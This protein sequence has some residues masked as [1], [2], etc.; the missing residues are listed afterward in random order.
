[1]RLLITKMEV[2]TLPPHSTHV[3]TKKKASLLRIA[4]VSLS[5]SNTFNPL[6]YIID[7][8]FLWMKI[9]GERYFLAKLDTRAGKNSKQLNLV[10]DPLV[11]V[12][13][14]NISKFELQVL[15]EARCT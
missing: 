5:L 13:F 7:E 12:E 9:H 14:E 3:Y 6:N 1:M 2:I 10:V 11:S 8:A 4:G 15:I